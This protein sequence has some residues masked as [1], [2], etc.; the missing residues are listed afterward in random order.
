MNGSYDESLG[1]QFWR[2]LRGSCDIGF[3]GIRMGA[4]VFD[5]TTGFPEPVNR[6]W[7]QIRVDR[8]PKM[9]SG[10]ISVGQIVRLSICVGE[11]GFLENWVIWDPDRSSSF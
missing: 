1:Y 8:T 6:I 10:E 11:S 7:G 5:L 9:S 4:R 3:V 2:M